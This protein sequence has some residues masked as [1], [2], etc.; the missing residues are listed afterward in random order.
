MAVESDLPN[1]QPKRRGRP[2]LGPDAPRSDKRP[3]SIRL[4]DEEWAKLQRLG[5]PWLEQAIR[6]AKEPE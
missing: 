3:R 4:G 6:R 5:T 1:R 2:A